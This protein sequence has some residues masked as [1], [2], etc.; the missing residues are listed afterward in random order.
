MAKLTL[1]DITSGHGSADLH[2]ANNTLLET[3]LENTLSRDGTTPNTMSAD[4]D[5]NGNSILN[6]SNFNSDF[7]VRGDWLTAT[8]YSVGD[9]VHVPVSDPGANGGSSF[10]A[11]T[12][13]T[14]G[15][16]DTDLASGYWLPLAS[17]GSAGANGGI[18]SANNLSDLDNLTTSL[19]N[20]LTA[21]GGLATADIADD[22]ITLAKMAAGTDGN[23][24]TYDASGDPAYVATGTSGQVLTSNGAGAAPT[25]QSSANVAAS[26]A[27]MEAA[28]STTAN[29][30]P[31]RQHFHPGMPKAWGQFAGSDG[32]LAASYNVASVAKLGTGSY[33]VTFTTAMSSANYAVLV[34]CR[35]TTGDVGVHGGVQYT[36]AKVAGSFHI[37][38]HLDSTEAAVNTTEVYFQ[39]LGD[40]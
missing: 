18:Q 5:M 14:S 37:Y 10:Y 30:T 19:D 6:A 15:V 20:L 34:T 28:T 40:I 22:A 11:Q 24:I 36:L 35:A 29:V 32:T 2:N 23:L 38:T 26:Q 17:R 3:A 4:L 21:H 33:K 39:V 16:F 9:V 25:F 13:H 8:A 31:G 1:T 7:N 12:A 27:E